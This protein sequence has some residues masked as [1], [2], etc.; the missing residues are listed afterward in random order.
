MADS[1]FDIVSKLDRQ[2]ADNALNQAMKE[3]S[4]RYDFKNTGALLEWKG[5]EGIEITANADERALAVLDVFKEKLV[6][7]GISLKALETGDPRQSGKDVKINGTFSQG[8]S[9]EQAKKVSKLIRDEGPKGVK[10]QI[11]GDELRVTSK[12]RD[13]LQEV[14]ALLKGADLDFAVQFVNYR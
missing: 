14:I 13:D 4:T 8:I 3:I 12:K 1:S 6:K 10:V 2:E 9:T 7:R 5:E 11:Q